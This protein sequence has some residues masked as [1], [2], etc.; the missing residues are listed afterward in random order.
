MVTFP[1]DAE[2]LAKLQ[3]YY[4]RWRS[5]PSYAKI[6][7]LLGIASRSAAGKVLNRLRK[8][9]Y[10]TRTPDEVWVPTRRFFERPLSDFHIP[11]GHPV[12]TGDVGGEAYVVD[13]YLVDTPSK[14]TLIPVKGDSMTGV[15]IFDGD[16]AV[17]ERDRTAGVGDIVVALV[18]GEMTL[19]TL[20]QRGDQTVLAPANPDYPEITPQGALEILGVMVG[21]VRKYGRKS[22]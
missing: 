13:E 17:V 16:L 6:G 9:D 5:L 1:K 22:P 11:A 12:T 20:A 8:E 4:A 7:R 15:G 18:D 21:L 2:Y 19:K 14:T 10:L 3:D